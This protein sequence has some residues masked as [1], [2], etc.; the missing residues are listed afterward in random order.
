[1]RDL[2]YAD[3]D[4]E[5]KTQLAKQQA[6]QKKQSATSKI[7]STVFLLNQQ[8]QVQVTLDT[9]QQQLDKQTKEHRQRMEELEEKKRKQEEAHQ[10]TIKQL[11]EQQDKLNQVLVQLKNAVL[12]SQALDDAQAV[13]S[14][15]TPAPQPV[16]ES[17]GETSS[18][19]GFHS[20]PPQQLSPD[21]LARIATMLNTHGLVAGEEKSNAALLELQCIIEQKPFK[22]SGST[23]VQGDL[24][25][26]YGPVVHSTPRPEPFADSDK[27]DQVKLPGKGKGGKGDKGDSG[28]TGA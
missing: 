10:A 17:P 18:S 23:E 5:L 26:N 14:S 8:K 25:S 1:M 16:R 12:K 24:Q 6:L 4:P 19:H 13:T 21:M 22:P 27:V 3:E 9:V 20:A 28:I 2:G 11:E 15:V 7:T